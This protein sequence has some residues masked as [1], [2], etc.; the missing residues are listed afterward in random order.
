MEVT[1]ITGRVS[2]ST[3]MTLAPFALSIL[4]ISDSSQES[5]EFFAARDIS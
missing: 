4:W 3:S 5:E 2:I 1:F